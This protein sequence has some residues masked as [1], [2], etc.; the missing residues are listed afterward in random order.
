MRTVKSVGETN[1]EWGQTKGKTEK[2][3]KLFGDGVWVKV[4]QDKG[5]Q[6]SQTTIGGRGGEE[7]GEEKKNHLYA[8]IYAGKNRKYPL[9][10]IKYGKK[11]Q[12]KHIFN[13]NKLYSKNWLSFFMFIFLNVLFS[14]NFL[15]FIN[16]NFKFVGIK[17]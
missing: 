5:G 2:E 15:Q 4:Q 10:S 1:V 12:K 13:I 14:P 8:N 9:E 11:Q 7:T 17:R 3:G 16:C 6:W